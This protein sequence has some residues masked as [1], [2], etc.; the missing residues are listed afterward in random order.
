MF[1]EIQRFDVF[2]HCCHSESIGLPLPSAY[3]QSVTVVTFRRRVEK[4]PV[5]KMSKLDT[6]DSI[7]R[8]N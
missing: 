1:N 8:I 7:F 6:I 2:C 4:T 3:L 5:T